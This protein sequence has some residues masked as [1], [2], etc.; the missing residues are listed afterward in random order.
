MS[1]PLLLV[2]W[3]QPVTWS[4]LTITGLGSVIFCTSKKKGELDTDFAREISTMD[5]TGT[6]IILETYQIVLSKINAFI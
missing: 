4:H 2:H 1:L 6:W 5:P 3:Q